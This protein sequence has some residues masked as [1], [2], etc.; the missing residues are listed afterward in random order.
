MKKIVIL[1]VMLFALNIA[2]GLGKRIQIN[3]FTG[4][5]GSV[6]ICFSN[7]NGCLSSI[8]ISS[9]F[10]KV[11]K[12]DPCITPSQAATPTGSI[13]LCENS[14]NSIYTTAGATDATDY[15]WE[16][17]PIGA[18]TITGTGTTGTVDWNDTYTGMATIHVKGTNGPGCEGAF[19]DDIAITID[20]N[21]PVSVT[22]FATPAGAICDGTNVT[23]TAT[24]I[25][26]GT[27]PTYQW[28]L[29]SMAVG[30]NSSSYS[31]SSLSNNDSVICKMTS[32]AIC[33]NG[34][35]TSSDTVV[36]SVNPN[37]VEGVNVAATP[38][39]AICDGTNVTFTATPIN[40]GTNPTYQWFLNS[41]AVGTNSSSYSNSSLSNNDS[42][43]CKMTSNADCINGNVAN[44][45][46]IVMSVTQYLP[47]G[48]SM[49]VTPSGTICEGSMVTFTA[50]PANGGINPS[51]L[52]FLN[53]LAVGSN[54]SI[55]S[56]TSFLNN[57]SIICEMISNSA[58][59]NGSPSTKDTTVL[60]VNP[61]IQA[62]VAVSA[63][64]TGAI[65]TGTSVT[66]TATPTNGVTNPVYQWYLNGIAV[67]TNS[68][69]YSNNT[70]SNN[71][72]IICT[73]TLSGT[74]ING[75]PL[76]AD[77]VVMTVNQNL[78]AS[79]AIAPNPGS[80][81]CSG[82]CVTFTATPNNG[83]TSPGYQ[84]RL[85]G[86][87][88]GTNSP[89]Y[90]NCQLANSDHIKCWMASNAACVTGSPA[91]S[92]VVTMTVGPNL[93]PGVSVSASPDSIICSGSC[94]T[95]TA[96]PV[97]GGTAPTYQWMLN[98]GSVGT[99]SSTYSNCS[100]TNGD[101]VS[102]VM[103]SNATCISGSNSPSSNVVTMT[104][105]NVVA[106]ASS[107]PST[108]CLGGCSTVSATGGG[109]YTW[110]N[111]ITTATQ[112]VCPVTTTSYTVTITNNGCSA[113]ALTTVIVD[114]LN[115]TVSATPSSI[116]QGD[117]STISATGGVNYAWSDGETTPS[118][119]VCPTVTTQY[120]LNVSDM[121]G[122]TASDCA[123]IVVNTTPVITQNGSDLQTSSASSYQWYL[124]GNLLVGATSQ[125]YTPLQNGN[126]TVLVTDISGCSATSLPFNVTWMGVNEIEQDNFI[127][128][129]PNPA[130]DKITIETAKFSQIQISNIHSQLIKTLVTN[131][132]KTK[133][134]IS[135]FPCGVYVVEVKSENSTVY[136]KFVK[137]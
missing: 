16:I 2:M 104:V 98:G 22:L 109:T 52:W 14:P 69:T 123:T 121:F 129:Y 7:E 12:F 38:A 39:G 31:N 70:L 77:T 99:N 111:I 10:G 58:C 83:G 131:G 114:V 29:N 18:G 35:A 102:V 117:C 89:T 94:V 103:T 15:V 53:G 91:S 3:S 66:F 88:V 82:T 137:E 101:H 106:N 124:D 36:M 45:D 80:A 30:T 17:L 28:F 56:S 75:N 5:K 65:C 74:C 132:Q 11:R 96:T 60:A 26:G 44:S 59:I 25:N 57:D 92:N 90:T 42:V 64:P 76:T 84:W 24:P 54:S 127:A 120:C 85:N 41:M 130:N 134:D 105:H 47:I 73:M 133:I 136:K 8:S 6:G 107:N 34:N 43:I 33:I 87:I 21:L 49:S 100:F 135:S 97:S 19:S 20:P 46:T 116:C 110:S 86:V 68:S 63:N 55:Y 37:L 112:T 126:Y 128:L 13:N 4:I 118:I 23:F 1:L 79:V 78:P 27:N 62:S 95:F 122:C 115:P 50:I 67:G 72:S 9:D 119:I 48:V 71:D 40:G 81:I 108:I 113:S 125:T 32:N 51:Y 93:L 61:N